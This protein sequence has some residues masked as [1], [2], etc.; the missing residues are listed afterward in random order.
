MLKQYKVPLPDLETQRTI[1]TQIEEEQRLVNANKE[2]IRLFEDKIKT[3]INRV[4]GEDDTT[5][6]KGMTYGSQFCCLHSMSNY[7]SGKYQFT[8][9]VCHMLYIA[10]LFRDAADQQSCTDVIS[11]YCR[12]GRLYPQGRRKT[13]CT[14]PAH[15]A[16]F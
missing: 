2:L 13:T 12:P 4:W 11:E 9:L 14:M 7:Q 16:A 6:V 15:R 5:I 3:T 1:V 10:S 8:V